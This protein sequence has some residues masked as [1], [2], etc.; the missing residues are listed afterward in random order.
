MKKTVNFIFVVCMVAFVSSTCFAI[1]LN[2]EKQG[3]WKKKMG[4]ERGCEGCFSFKVHALLKFGD[5][6]GLSDEQTEKIKD[7]DYNLKK[8][9]IKEDA[10]IKLTSLDIRQEMEKD[11]ININTVNDLI[12]KKYAVKSKKSK[13]E[14]EAFAKLKKIITKEQFK[15]L[16]EIRSEEMKQRMCDRKMCAEHK[17]HGKHGKNKH[18]NDE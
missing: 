16:K 13:E 14:V 4:N 3:F 9:T 18:H 11:D 5:K 10:E 7:L 1:G 2:K 6:I 15:K 17:E 8:S 12:D